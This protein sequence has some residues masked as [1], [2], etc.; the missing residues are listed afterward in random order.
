MD[1]LRT[2]GFCVSA[3]FA[4]ASAEC[5]APAATRPNIVLLLADDLGYRDLGCYG[6][7]DIHTPAIDRLAKQGVRFTQCYANGPECTP[8][9][10]ALLSG[11]YPQR[12]G[13][14]ECAIG[15]GNVGRYD[16][17]IRLRATDD[18][19]LPADDNNLSNPLAKVG[20][21]TAI[22]GKWHLGY[23]DKFSPMRHG[24]TH[25]YYCL[26][27]GMDY[28]HHIEEPPAGEMVV[29]RN[30]V[31]EYQHAYF[32]SLVTNDAVQF[33]AR[34]AK[35][36]FFLYVPFTAPHAPYQGPND[37]RPTPLPADSSLWKQ[38]AAPPEVYRAMVESLDKAVGRICDT[39]AA[40]GLA[41]NTLVL[42]LS[43][44]GGTASARPTGLR[45][46]KGTTFEGGIRIPC[47]ARWP[48]QIPTG[49]T[50]DQLAA[51]FDLTHSMLRAGGATATSQLDGVDV[52]RNIEQGRHQWSRT[53]FWRGR[54]GQRTW[55]AVRQD[56]WKFVSEQNGGKSTEYLFHIAA[57]EGEQN[58]LLSAEADRASRMRLLLAE[59]Q[60]NVRPRRP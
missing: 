14:L 21:A 23:G 12:P 53:L 59:W 31:P 40:H 44:N 43:D 7:R 51:T 10:A 33:I 6:C 25:A 57:D 27:G 11:Q 37:D 35:R 54:R 22:C 38:S 8:T 52:L 20:Y 1:W 18:L 13:G 26:G 5:A 34:H 19:G 39:L 48:D 29:R 4:M 15:V 16:D 3:L 36:P 28:F 50:C 60:D 46:I 30:G 55:L 41:D 32:T 2:V 17:A 49:L 45:G 58:N 56:Q 24:F 47:I 42:F 9:R